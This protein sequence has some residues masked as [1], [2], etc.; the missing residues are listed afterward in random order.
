VVALESTVLTHGLPRPLNLEVGRQLE[1]EVRAGGA[2][3]ATIAVVE[4]TARIGLNPTELEMIAV[5]EGV[6][7]LSTK[8][9]PVALARGQSGGTTVA[10]TASLAHAAGIQVFAT[11]GIGG[12]HRGPI[13]DVSADLPELQRTPILVVC[14]GAKSILDLPATREA[15]E[16]LGIL[17]LGWRTHVF[18]EFYTRGSD[19][20]VDATVDNAAEVAAIWSAHRRSGARSAIVLCVPVPE[21]AALDRAELDA[22]TGRAL[23][24]A[25]AR[26]VTG[27]ALT[28]Y[29]LGEIARQTGGASLDANVALLRNNARVAAEVAAHIARS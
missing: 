18:P 2:T 21:T 11:G 10:A 4:G 12:V 29:L 8:D 14:A 15:L 28:P 19:I 6:T 22:V 9:L 7:K 26:R 27:K 25:T 17:V 24:A 1:V 23:A 13:F 5:Q 20:E 3:P 16:T